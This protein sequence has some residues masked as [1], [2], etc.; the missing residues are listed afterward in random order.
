MS[1]LVCES[2]TISYVGKTIF[3]SW[4]FTVQSFN[5]WKLYYTN[6]SY[7]T[8]EGFN[9]TRQDVI[10]NCMLLFSW[11]FFF[12]TVV[13]KFLKKWQVSLLIIWST[14]LFVKYVNINEKPKHYGLLIFVWQYCYTKIKEFNTKKTVI[15][16]NLSILFF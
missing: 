15:Q 10:I 4:M 16:I 5:I 9:K 14:F 6:W 7:S 8:I 11:L 13:A 12:W 1:G 2:T 3:N